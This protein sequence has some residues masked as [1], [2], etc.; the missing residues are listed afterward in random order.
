VI[1]ARPHARPVAALDVAA[2]VLARGPADGVVRAVTRH[3]VHV[4]L[5]GW[6]LTVTGAGVPA[7]PNAIRVGGEPGSASAGAPAR[8]EPGLLRAGAL[9][10]RWDAGAPPVWE[11][12]LASLA[13]APAPAL[14]ARG[15]AILA[16]LGAR[17]PAL[18]ACV[19]R[20]IERPAELLGLGPGLT[21]EGDDLLAGAA[22]VLA[23]RGTR[24]ELPHDMRARTTGLAATLLE[25][26]AAGAAPAPAH[27]VVDSACAGWRSALEDLCRLGASTGRAWGAG[28]AF[29]LQV[30]FGSQSR[31]VSEATAPAAPPSA[32]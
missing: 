8:L 6:V 13:A 9:A 22:A 14:A 10:V 7:L 30:G 23:A 11:P 26:A 32:P 17:V 16:A 18:A 4:D 12:R 1:G 28:L 31:A 24:L 27:A 21:P 2:P 20:A 19:P 25:L 3:A 5:G 29:G 15:A